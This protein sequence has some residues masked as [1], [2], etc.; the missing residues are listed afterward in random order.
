M[1]ATVAVST[2]SIVVDTPLPLR[3]YRPYLTDIAA[4]LH[5]RT[6]DS[7][8]NYGEFSADTKP[9]AD[10]IEV[11]I[12]NAYAEVRMLVGDEIATRL[13]P[14]AKKAVILNTCMMIERSYYP[15][16]AADRDSSAYELFREEYN[17]YIKTLIESVVDPSPG[18][19][20]VYSV[21]LATDISAGSDVFSA[22]DR[23]I[24]S[25]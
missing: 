15:E 7:N 20:G 5:A 2:S 3:R 10:H 12:D 21:D 9:T 6:Q 24:G 1:S 17:T 11:L 25:Y 23:V 14:A 22:Y 16:Q 4:H 19:R 13:W 18:T 8:N